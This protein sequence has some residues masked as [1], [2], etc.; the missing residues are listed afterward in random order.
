MARR[1]LEAVAALGAVAFIVL[2]AWSFYGSDSTSLCWSY[3]GKPD[4]AKPVA[5]RG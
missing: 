3:W 4:F 5:C 1:L 2:G